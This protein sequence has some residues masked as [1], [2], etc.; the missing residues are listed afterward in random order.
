MNNTI[1]NR[2][3]EIK[4]ENIVYLIFIIIILLGIYANNNEIDYFLN[5]NEDSKNNYYYTM[6]IIFLIVVIISSYY[7]YKSYIEVTNTKYLDK[8]KTK[9]YNKLNLI[10]NGLAFLSAIIYLYIAITDTNIEVEISL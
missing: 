10:A 3:K 5:N 2:I 1:E 8:S 7:F 6:I 9:E 4:I